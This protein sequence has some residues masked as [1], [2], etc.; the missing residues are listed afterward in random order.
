MKHE[1]D[2]NRHE[3]CHWTSER[4]ISAGWPGLL[5][6]GC[7]ST[8]NLELTCCRV[9]RSILLHR[10]YSGFLCC[11]PSLKQAGPPRGQTLGCRQARQLPH[12]AAQFCDALARIGPRY[13]HRAG[14]VGAQRCCHDHDLYPRHESARHWSSQSLERPTPHRSQ[15]ALRGCQCPVHVT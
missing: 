9:E 13:P 2:Y 8:R 11:A 1:R 10:S 6:A 4:S 12:L 5:Q 14:T 15:A 7:V 3:R